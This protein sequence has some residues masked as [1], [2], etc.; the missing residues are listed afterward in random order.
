M[1]MYARFYYCTKSLKLVVNYRVK[2]K[3]K[4]P[5]TIYFFLPPKYLQFKYVM[6]LYW[7]CRFQW[8]LLSSIIILSY[9]IP[10]MYSP[11]YNVD[12]VSCPCSVTPLAV[13]HAVADFIDANVDEH[14]E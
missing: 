11:T 7:E 10:G 9:S 13:Q 6:L 5:Q 8:Q 14:D 3:K 12:H 4:N 1:L 2:L